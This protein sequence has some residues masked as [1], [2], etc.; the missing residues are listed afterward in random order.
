LLSEPKALQQLW[1]SPAQE[2]SVIQVTRQ[3]VRRLQTK[4]DEE[5]KEME[6]LCFD[7]CA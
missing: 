6:L 2:N 3:K 7:E 4:R 5:V 1:H